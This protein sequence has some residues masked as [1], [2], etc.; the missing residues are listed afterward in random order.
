MVKLGR[1]YGSGIAILRLHL[2]Y[3]SKTKRWATLV[4]DA[5][6]GEKGCE[7]GTVTSPTCLL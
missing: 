7:G 2:E 5:V 3:D 1:E 4:G 6:A